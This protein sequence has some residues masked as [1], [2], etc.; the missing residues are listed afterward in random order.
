[1]ESISYIYDVFISWTGKNIK[2]KNTIKE[3]LKKEGLIFYDSEEHCKGNF[4]EDFTGTLYNSKDDETA[5]IKNR[6]LNC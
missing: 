1:M 5:R 2:E 4:R 6:R 3:A